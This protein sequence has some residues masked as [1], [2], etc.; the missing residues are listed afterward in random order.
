MPKSGHDARNPQAPFDVVVIGASW[1]G[2]HALCQLLP[3]LPPHF[4][5][6][7]VIVQHRA[8]RPP[9]LLADILSRQTPLRVVEAEQGARP[10]P[11]VI[12]LAIPGRHVAFDAGGHLQLTDAPRVNFVRPSIDVL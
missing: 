3:S 8:D 10:E 2:V 5:T 7:I 1:G 9:F 11:G 12:Y 6:P 4:S